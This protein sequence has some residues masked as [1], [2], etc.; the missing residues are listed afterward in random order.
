MVQ[1][2]FAKTSNIL[3]ILWPWLLLCKTLP[4]KEYAA[5]TSFLQYT[6]WIFTMA[7]SRIQ[8]IVFQHVLFNFII[9]N[10]I[11]VKWVKYFSGKFEIK[12]WTW[13]ITFRVTA[14]QKHLSWSSFS[15]KL[16]EFSLLLKQTS[17]RTGFSYEM[18]TKCSRQILGICFLV[19]FDE[20]CIN[21]NKREHTASN[22]RR[23]L[24]SN[25][26]PSSIDSMIF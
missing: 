23:I 6:H 7:V 20:K 25:S 18:F 16:I 11:I 14:L 5:Q 13:N 3:I 2:K 8:P 10:D 19:G 12:R 15:F 9:E 21:K 17:L 24:L 22:T 1:E 4:D 26:F